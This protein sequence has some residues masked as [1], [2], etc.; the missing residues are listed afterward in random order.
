MLQVLDRLGY[1]GT[2][3]R[4]RYGAGGDEEDPFEIAVVETTVLDLGEDESRVIEVGTG[5][6]AL[7]DTASIEVD[8]NQLGVLETAVEDIR[9]SQRAEVHIHPRK[10]AAVDGGGVEKTESEGRSGEKDVGKGRVPE[11]AAHEA[12]PR[13]IH[14]AEID[15]IEIDIDGAFLGAKSVDQPLGGLLGRWRMFPAEGSLGE[16]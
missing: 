11:T 1:I 5:K 9:V 16:G 4:N 2:V 14:P 8:M 10:I 7:P 6:G 12:H 3:G 15:M 13:E